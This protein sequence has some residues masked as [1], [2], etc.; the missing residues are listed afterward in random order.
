MA[1]CTTAVY[2]ERTEQTRQHILEGIEHPYIN[3]IHTNSNGFKWYI[4]T[5]GYYHIIKPE[6]LKVNTGEIMCTLAYYRLKADDTLIR[7]GDNGYFYD[8]EKVIEEYN[9]VG[10]EED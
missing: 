8:K 9:K 3:Q 4:N 10:T 2:D 5:R 7:E 6:R 1:K